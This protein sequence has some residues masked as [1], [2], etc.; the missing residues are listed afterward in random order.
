MHPLAKALF[1]KT[2]HFIYEYN[3]KP[4]QL[5]SGKLSHH[6]FN[7]KKITLHPEYLWELSKAICEELLP[8]NQIPVPKAVGGMTLGADPI[9]YGISFYYFQKG[10]ICYPLIV[11]KETKEHGTKKRIEGLIENL[12]EVLVV[13]DVIT[14]A[15][16]TLKAI[17]AFREMNLKVQHV[18]CIIDREEG[19]KEA[20]LQEGIYLHSLWKKSDFVKVE[21]F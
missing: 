4:F 16:S 14:T 15:S 5:S 11:R 19:G 8:K 6:Y 2:H 9:A 3:E 21:S 12:D 1:D 13:D 7:C 17:S 20:L 10:V 18:V